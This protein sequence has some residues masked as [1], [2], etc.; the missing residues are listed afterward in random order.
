M[1]RMVLSVLAVAAISSAYAIPDDYV[2]GLAPFPYARPLSATVM[3]EGLAEWATVYV[4]RKS[5]FE[6][7]TSV[8]MT[9]SM[10]S[11]RVVAVLI[12]GELAADPSDGRLTS[13]V[14]S[15]LRC[16][17]ISSATIVSCGDCALAAAEAAKSLRSVTGLVL[18]LEGK[19]TKIDIGKPVF[20]AADAHASLATAISRASV[21][22]PETRKRLFMEASLARY[23][24]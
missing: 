9:P 15:I 5:D 7:Y 11:S 2:L 19:N 1:K 24:P 10:V 21:L 18:F 3:D 6:P 14:A 8:L 16:K 20:I 23:A 12:D 22:S 4:A 13:L 17:G